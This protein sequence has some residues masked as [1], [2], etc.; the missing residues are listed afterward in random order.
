VNAEEFVWKCAAFF[1]AI[2][3]C[4]L[5]FPAATVLA[6]LHGGDEAIRIARGPGDAVTIENGGNEFEG[7]RERNAMSLGD[8]I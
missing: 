1:E 2:A 4:F 3:L 7:E 5:L 8:V 6:A